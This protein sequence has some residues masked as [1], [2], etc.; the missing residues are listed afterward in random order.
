M[1]GVKKRKKKLQK[2]IFKTNMI[3]NISHAFYKDDAVDGS[4][5]K[6]YLRKI[7]LQKDKNPKK[8]IKN[9]QEEK[10]NT[11]YILSKID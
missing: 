9:V 3:I 6:N 11:K 4:F 10:I 7:L 2:E 8:K 5:K 1:L